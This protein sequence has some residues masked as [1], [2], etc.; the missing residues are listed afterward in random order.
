MLPGPAE[1]PAGD[2]VGED[3]VGDARGE[4]GAIAGGAEPYEL[5]YFG[6]GDWRAGEGAATKQQ[7]P[8]ADTDG[9]PGSAQACPSGA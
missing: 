5:G 2:E 4:T 8:W 6:G 1:E 3:F 7:H 9:G